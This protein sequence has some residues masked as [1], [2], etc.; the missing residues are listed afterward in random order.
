[1][2]LADTTVVH[3]EVIA[4]TCA[5]VE[6]ILSWLEQAAADVG[7]ESKLLGLFAQQCDRGHPFISGHAS[8]EAFEKTFN[9]RLKPI[10]MTALSGYLP[11]RYTDYLA[12]TPV[13]VPQGIEQYV[14]LVRIVPKKPFNPM[15]LFASVKSE[16]FR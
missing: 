15:D 9:C 7:I 11:D 12:E 6:H 5:G 3:Y 8:R 16:N 4:K 10:K 14:A 1:M 2:Q 13:V